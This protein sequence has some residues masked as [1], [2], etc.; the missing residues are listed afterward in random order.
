M[1]IHF[2]EIAVLLAVS[3][4]FGL[5]IG[6]V[7]RR[8]SLGRRV[9]SGGAIP[10]ERLAAVTGQGAALAEP[11]EQ[12]NAAT[13]VAAESVSSEVVA[14]APA[15]S[16]GA[17]VVPAQAPP[18]SPTIESAAPSPMAAPVG[19]D[20][21]P[22][23]Q[24]VAASV[25]LSGGPS[26][27]LQQPAPLEAS[28]PAHEPAS[29]AAPVA[30]SQQN[31]TAAGAA[32]SA[33][34]PTPAPAGWSAA[35]RSEQTPP[36]A[37]GAWPQASEVAS[38]SSAPGVAWSGEIRGRRDHAH[39]STPEPSTAAAQSAPNA[40]WTQRPAVSGDLGAAIAAA[41]TAVEA[42]LVKSGL[43]PAEPAIREG[44]A[45]GRPDG[46]GSPLGRRDDLKKINGLGPVDESML[47]GMGVFHFDQIVDWDDKEILWL[48]NHV[49][50]VG[51]IAREGWQAQ[52]RDLVRDRQGVAEADR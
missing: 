15:A 19:V 41:Q 33:P 39:D 49:F 44:A 21:V 45:F 36:P 52:A 48:E 43:D 12:A 25:A 38:P 50:E 1:L 23:A 4:A 42:A 30:P 22:V 47:N 10:A 24:P 13:P 46:L 17:V 20:G 35:A 37:A 27:A 7:A 14:T 2:I 31:G 11:A 51:R 16:P 3:Y 29:A 32:V 26:G 18:S 5:G 6:L 8:A 40:D 9:E 34:T 28:P